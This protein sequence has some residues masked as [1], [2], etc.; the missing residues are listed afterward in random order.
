MSDH[1]ATRET[2][3]IAQEREMLYFESQRLNEILDRPNRALSAA[4]GMVAMM[5]SEHN[6]ENIR[7]MARTELGRGYLPAAMAGNVEEASRNAAIMGVHHAIEQL[8]TGETGPDFSGMAPPEVL[9]RQLSHDLT[10]FYENAQHWDF[11]KQFGPSSRR[12]V[13]RI[14]GHLWYAIK[15]VERVHIKGGL[16]RV[17]GMTR[18]EGAR[19]KIKGELVQQIWSSHAQGVIRTAKERGARVMWVAERD[20]CLTCLALS[21]HVVNPGAGFNADA[22]FG[23][24]PL[25]VLGKLFGPP[26]H[27]FCRCHLEIW[28]GLMP[29][30]PDA[31]LNISATMPEALQREARRSAVMMLS[32]YA[33]KKEKVSAADRLLRAGAALP[34]SVVARAQRMVERGTN[35]G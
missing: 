14:N 21:G 24:R 9:L 26:R 27:P 15:H 6:E 25:P 18:L 35:S 19:S 3:R 29:R 5:R 2:L 32:G 30:D 12:T 31:G 10:Q 34:K 28:E 33:S 8:V 13:K 11:S 20:A 4:Q 16:S 17:E 22:T 23:R 1:G 7:D